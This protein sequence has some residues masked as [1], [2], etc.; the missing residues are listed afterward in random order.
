MAR[1]PEGTPMQRAASGL[2]ATCAQLLGGVYGSRIVLLVGSGDNG[3]DALY[4]GARLAHCGA[5]W[6]R[7]WS[8]A[9]PTRVGPACGPRP[10]HGR[11]ARDAAVVDRADLVIDGILGIGGEAVCVRPW[12]RSR[13][14][15]G[16]RVRGGRRRRTQRRSTRR[17]GWSRVLRSS[18]R[19]GDVRD[20]EA[21]SARGPRR[22]AHRARRT[23]RH[24]PGA[25]PGRRDGRGASSGDVA[26]LLPTAS[27]ESDK[28]ARGVVGVVAGRR[29]TPG[30]RSSAL[31]VRL[32][33]APG[34]CV[35]PGRR[36]RPR[37]KIKRSGGRSRA[38]R[39]VVG[40]GLGQED[41][42]RDRPRHVLAQDW[43]SSTPMG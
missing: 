36:T 31:A 21:R 30:Q 6:M 2:A 20:V 37:S 14:G 27:A 1:L 13:S 42:A 19:H 41:D 10:P 4:A 26:G 25:V 33:E 17:P 7:C 3:G 22:L 39:P 34:W 40:P 29:R 24:R 38:A 9:A 11:V 16:I 32:R 12:T 15:V 18:R 35:T 23:R 28:Y 5:R 8:A 43:Y